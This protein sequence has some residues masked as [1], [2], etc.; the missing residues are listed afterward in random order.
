[1]FNLQAITLR[2]KKNL[3]VTM[4]W[5]IL[6]VIIDPGSPPWPNWYSARGGPQIPNFKPR[7]GYIRRLFHLSLRFM[8]FGGRSAHLGYLVHR[9][10][11]KTGTFLLD[12]A[13]SAKNEI[14]HDVENL[15]CVISKTLYH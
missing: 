5:N 3:D 13:H 7:L 2:L 14:V 4:F 8:T 15:V 1:M 10:G 12:P 9:S 6:Q 11:R